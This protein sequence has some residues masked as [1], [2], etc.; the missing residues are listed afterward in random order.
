M[1]AGG[2]RAIFDIGGGLDVFTG[3]RTFVRIDAGDRMVRLP[4]PT[5]VDGFTLRETAFFSHDFRLSV[6]GGLVW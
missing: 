5:L 3:D 2:T 4:A 1:A 6:G